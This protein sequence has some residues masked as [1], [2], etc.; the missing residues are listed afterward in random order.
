[1]LSILSNQINEPSDIYKGY[2]NS[3]NVDIADQSYPHPT[4]TH[5]HQSSP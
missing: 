1:M 5:P 3:K 4:H 2:N